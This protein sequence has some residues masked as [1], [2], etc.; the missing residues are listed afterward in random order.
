VMLAGIEVMGYQF[1]AL[2]VARACERSKTER[3]GVVVN[4]SESPEVLSAAGQLSF[5]V[6]RRPR[7]PTV[8][9]GKCARQSLEEEEI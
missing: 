1:G 6:P 5:L 3:A 7:K 4:R 2:T 8:F 9:R